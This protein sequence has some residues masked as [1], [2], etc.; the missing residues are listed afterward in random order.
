MKIKIISGIIAILIAALFLYVILQP[1]IF[2]Y[3]PYLIHKSLFEK[4]DSNG[5]IVS[6]ITEES[7][8]VTFDVVASIFILWLTYKVSMFFFGREM[9]RRDK[10][11]KD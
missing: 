8:I 2:N 10:L 9:I 1:G 11:D 6:V 7:F 5:E 3:L 4:L